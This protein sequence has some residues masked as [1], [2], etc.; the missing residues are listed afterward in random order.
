MDFAGIHFDGDKIAKVVDQ[1]ERQ[2]K[3]KRDYIYPAKRVDMD[4]KGNLL[5][6]GKW[7]SVGDRSYLDWDDAE[8][9]ADE[10]AL[11]SSQIVVS[12]KKASLEMNRSAYVQLLNRLDIPTRFADK[13][14]GDKHAPEVRSMLVRELLNRDDRKFLV[15]TM[16][17]KVRAVLSDRYKILDNSDLFFQSAE[18]FKEVNA[19]MWQARLWNDGGGFEM[20]ATAQHIAGE[21]KTDRTF[22]PGDGWQSRW[23]GTEGDVHN[24]AGR[25][26]NSETGQGGCNANLSILRRVCANFCVWTDGVSVIHAGGHISADDGLLMSDETR[27]K[28]NDLVWLKVRD[29][30]TT[31]FDEGKFRA[32]IDRLNDCTKDVIEEPIKVVDKLADEYAISESRKSAILTELLG[33]GDRSRYGLVQAITEGADADGI[34]DEESSMLNTIGGQLIESDQHYAALVG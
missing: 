19:Q 6:E 22:D 17:G 29:A 16:K 11:G 13:V 27:Q 24:P 8:A 33:S 31:A 7:F 12:D 3:L 14:S 10:Q 23:Y 1:I 5:L 28:E 20:F 21:V 26:S 30:I 15:R 34:S 32:Y 25:V 9:A 2:K 4:D 18:K